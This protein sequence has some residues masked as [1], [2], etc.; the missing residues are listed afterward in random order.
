MQ[1]NNKYQI[2]CRWKYHY[3]KWPIKVVNSQSYTNASSFSYPGYPG[4]FCDTKW[5]LQI[6][7]L[8]HNDKLII[9]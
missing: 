3:C 4:N 8:T 2:V 9:W 6:D 1:T 7:L 5:L